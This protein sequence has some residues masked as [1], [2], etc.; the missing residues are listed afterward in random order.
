[1]SNLV[2]TNIG[3]QHIANAA[4]NGFKISVTNFRV[5][6]YSYGA[7]DLPQVTATELNLSPNSTAYD[8]TAIEIL[9]NASVQFE[10][11]IPTGETLSIGEIGLYLSDGNLFAIGKVFPL[12]SKDK[13]TSFTIKTIVSATNNALAEVISV[14]VSPL[15]TLP[16]LNVDKLPK[17]LPLDSTANTTSNAIIINDAGTSLDGDSPF[18]GATLAIKLES[19]WSFIGF[20]KVATCIP[21]LINNTGGTE[22]FI[23][24]PNTSGFWLNEGEHVLVQVLTGGAS[25]LTRRCKYS[26]ELN[27]AQ[28]VFLPESSFKNVISQGLD[29]DS[30]LSIWRDSSIAYPDRRTASATQVLFAGEST[31]NTSWDTSVPVAG[32]LKISK[33]FINN[34]AEGQYMFDLLPTVPKSYHDKN[35][36]LLFLNGK[37]QAFN[38]FSV[39]DNRIV[40]IPVSK[41]TKVS[42]YI[43]YRIDSTGAAFRLYT[44]LIQSSALT[45]YKGSPSFSL[46]IVPVST[47]ESMGFEFSG[48]KGLEVQTDWGIVNSSVVFNA[49][50]SIDTLMLVWGSEYIINSYSQPKQYEWLSN[51]NHFD[52][53]TNTYKFKIFDT[54]NTTSITGSKE[55]ILFIDGNIIA[56]TDYSI[57]GIEIVIDKA[58]IVIPYN[59]VVRFLWI[60]SKIANIS[61]LSTVETVVT[62]K[63]L[64]VPLID[65]YTVN[66]ATLFSISTAPINDNYVIVFVDGLKQG[67]EDWKLQGNTSD[68]TTINF[69]QDVPSLGSKVDI[70]SFSED[71]SSSCVLVNQKYTIIRTDAANRDIYV[72]AGGVLVNSNKIFTLVFIDGLYVHRMDYSIIENCI[73]IYDT[74]NVLIGNKLNSFMFTLDNIEDIPLDVDIEIIVFCLTESINSRTDLVISRP[75][76]YIGLN[77]FSTESMYVSLNNT[78]LFIGPIY[79]H[80]S[81]Y[82]IVGTE[83]ILETPIPYS[84]LDPKKYSGLAAELLSFVSGENLINIE[85]ALS[86]AFSAA[87]PAR[88]TGPYWADPA[89]TNH[90]PNKMTMHRANFKSS[91]ATTYTFESPTRSS[92]ILVFISGALQNLGLDYAYTGIGQLQIFDVPNDYDVDIITFSTEEDVVGYRVDMLVAT[93]KSNTSTTYT[94]NYKLTDANSLLV[95]VS[96]VYFHKSW[97]TVDFSSAVSYTVVFN[98]NLVEG[99]DI[100]FCIWNSVKDK[101]SYTEM[102]VQLPNPTIGAKNIVLD[103]E[104]TKNNTLVFAGPIYQNKNTYSVKT[105]T[106]ELETAINYEYIA[107][108]NYR[109]MPITLCLFR[110]GKSKTRLITRDELRDGYVTKYGGDLKGPLYTVGDPQSDLEVANKQYVDRLSNDIADMRQLISNLYGVEASLSYSPVLSVAPNL[111][112]VG[113][114]V[115]IKIITASPGRQVELEVSGASGVFNKRSIKGVVNLDGTFTLGPLGIDNGFVDYLTVSAWVDGFKVANTVAIKITE[116]NVITGPAMIGSDKDVYAPYDYITYSI[117]DATPGG[118]VTWSTNGASLTNVP[119]GQPQFIG[120]DGTWSMQVPAGG[121]PINY[122]IE[123]FVDG[124]SLGTI[125]IIVSPSRADKLPVLV[126]SSSEIYRDEVLSITISDGKPFAPITFSAKAVGLGRSGPTD[127]AGLIDSDGKS[128]FGFRFTSPG[129]YIIYITINRNLFTHALKVNMVSPNDVLVTKQPDGYRAYIKQF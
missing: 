68:T 67:R 118:R 28:N 23:L 12:F 96:G 60:V 66:D 18:T 127:T 37:L 120:D 95:F 119:A 111:I 34:T 29:A 104:V 80:K 13:D 24:E 51:V 124:G 82:T 63:N 109:N 65:S 102:I 105:L 121:V 42:I 101:D 27:S 112:I 125:N 93:Q 16:R 117:A 38:A 55:Y 22:Y 25:G 123:L 4:L 99:L 9:N 21:T 87:K 100:E 103:D 32:E 107:P 77:R 33:T 110:T 19:E 40:T 92:N 35:N 126:Y 57:V 129:D 75:A 89:G 84:L 5:S 58:N 15:L 98:N 41:D 48:K 36:V 74:N 90:L 108:I 53:R 46:P 78:L 70:I 72:D 2:I 39:Y 71:K 47:L 115:I 114:S 81:S 113:G 86:T 44:E 128:N 45:E 50:P 88:N 10:C 106:L 97:Y 1:M 61:A 76:P 31:F 52:S 64:I 73:S 91:N 3:I 79:Q 7:L 11:V 49:N 85:S 14:E 56:P 43:F 94:V 20:T 54:V 30:T 26:K 8:I 17:P 83:A 6:A 69:L 122:I 116:A 62:D 59:T